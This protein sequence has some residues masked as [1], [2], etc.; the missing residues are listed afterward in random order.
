MVTRARRPRE[1]KTEHPHVV[2]TDG[3]AGGRARIAG[4]RLTVEFIIGL[5]RVGD[6]P[7][8]IVRAYPHVSLAQVHDAISYYYD[9]QVEID[10]E[11]ENSTPGKTL[12]RHGWTLGENGRA[13]RHAE[14]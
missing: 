6:A 11:I 5:L 9:H 1:V 8:D 4:T 7:E 10:R 14:A 3:T 13:V 2:K 12:E